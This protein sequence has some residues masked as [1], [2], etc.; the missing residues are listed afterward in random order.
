MILRYK[1]NFLSR[2]MRE[3]P[4]L[5]I[6]VDP[7]EMYPMSM[8]RAIVIPVKL[9]LDRPLEATT[10]N[11]PT[12]LPLWNLVLILV[13]NKVLR[14]ARSQSA[15]KPSEV[16]LLTV[17]ESLTLSPIETLAPNQQHHLFPNQ[18]KGVTPFIRFRTLLPI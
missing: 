3:K 5:A 8:L 6:T 4:A 15:T 16:V 1:H 7:G 14:M 12:A 9:V 2:R 13:A 10:E 17:K 11:P 18:P